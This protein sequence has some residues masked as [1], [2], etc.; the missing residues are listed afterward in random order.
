MKLGGKML[1]CLVGGL[2]VCATANAITEPAGTPYE[3]IIKKNVFSLRPP[4][5]PPDPEATKAPPP[6]I[7]LTGIT[8]LIGKVALMET[9]GTTP[10]PGESAKGKQFYMLH[11][12]EMQND[13]K[14]VAIDEKAGS[15]KVLNGGKEFTL[16]FDKDGSKL[17]ASP[18]PPMPGT[19]PGALPGLPPPPS[20]MMPSP[21]KTA[22]MNIPAF[23]A[24]AVRTGNQS[25]N[26]PGNALPGGFP[27]NTAG[28]GTPLPSF[29]SAAPLQ[30]AQPTEPQMGL[31]EQ[32]LMMEAQRE[33]TR[34]QVLSG[35]LPPLPPTSV[36]P[37][38]S[39]GS[40]APV[41][42]PNNPST[43]GLPRPGLPPLP[44]ALR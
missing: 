18:P 34:N 33:I 40:F 20:G 2:A 28:G 38:G 7:T 15:V 29:T 24:R 36:T 23:P 25:A 27:G 32:V 42:D 5:P 26:L 3:E 30:S 43:R 9:P 37:P 35:K 13:I 17:P 39:P 44:G 22:D 4:P 19:L 16:T 10:K 12:G 11:E 31:E 14:V 41:Q 1:L 8:T 6:K 21:M